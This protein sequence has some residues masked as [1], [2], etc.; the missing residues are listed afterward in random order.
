MEQYLRE[1]DRLKWLILSTRN[2]KCFRGRHLS[3]PS[4]MVMQG[5][6]S[7]DETH[8]EHRLSAVR[9]VLRRLQSEV[10]ALAH[11]RRDPRFR[12]ECARCLATLT[13]LMSRVQWPSRVELR[14]L[15]SR[16]RRRQRR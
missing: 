12:T 15:W 11:R 2:L 3:Q 4:P 10:L 14:E 6:H 8:R 9:D 1:P 16:E 5:V 13:R 7:I